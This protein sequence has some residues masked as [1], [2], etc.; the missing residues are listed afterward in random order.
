MFRLTRDEAEELLRSQ[1]VT[2]IQ[3]QGIKGGR[4]YLAYA[5]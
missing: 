1:N 5:D 3:T 2:S 4:A